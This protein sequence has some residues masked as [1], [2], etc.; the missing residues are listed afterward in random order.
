MGNHRFKFSDMMP[1][2]C[3]YKLIKD[4]SKRSKRQSRGTPPATTTENPFQ[5]KK[6]A[7]LPSRASYYFSSRGGEEEN[8]NLLSPLH[9]KTSDTLF[10]QEP[11]RRSKWRSQRKP[12]SPKGFNPPPQLELPRITTKP[13]KKQSIL[14]AAALGKQSRRSPSGIHRLRKRA[15]TPRAVNRRV[16]PGRKSLSKQGSGI[17]QSFAV[18]KSSS[19]PQQDFRESMVEM[20][21]ANNI[22][23]SKDLEELL[24][25]YLSLN[26]MEYHDV[27]VKVFEQI[28]LDLIL[29]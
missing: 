1:N 25:C 18:V 15:G 3:F 9:P 8:M 17:S 20:I 28:W 13:A 27:I 19:N 5:K 23:A 7:L 2:A 21:M 24:A 6:E 22:W 12:I 26:S 11:P 16:P 4:M 14:D 29:I 10:P